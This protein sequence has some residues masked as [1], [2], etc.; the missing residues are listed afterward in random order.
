MHCIYPSQI[1]KLKVSIFLNRVFFQV[2]CGLFNIR[3]LETKYDFYS[4]SLPRNTVYFSESYLILTASKSFEIILPCRRITFNFGYSQLLS[5][6][7][8]IFWGE[9]I[10]N[11]FK[12]TLNLWYWIF[13]FCNDNRTLLIYWLPSF[14]T[15]FRIGIFMTHSR[16]WN[17]SE[18]VI[19]RLC[20]GKDTCTWSRFFQLDA[21]I[22]D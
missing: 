6:L 19:A 4:L 13:K 9:F 8:N 10:H 3:I 14:R 1:Y 2:N 17:Y 18:S 22:P 20:Y 16:I 11:F 7:L 21:S 15:I 5:M 12:I